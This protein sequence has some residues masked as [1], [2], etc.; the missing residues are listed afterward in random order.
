MTTMS[1]ESTDLWQNHSLKYLE[2]AFRSDRC[3]ILA[4]PDGYGKKIRSCGD[5]IEIFIK[6]RGDILNTVSY[7]TNGC[8][9]TIAC[10]NTVVFLI[11]GKSVN[12]AW[13]I[14]PQSI[15][16][17]L[18]TLPEHDYHCAEMAVDALHLALLNLREL[19]RSP[20]KRAY[21]TRN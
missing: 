14:T 17:Y 18:E 16:D 21:L 6:T 5:S 2:M 7:Y 15:A 10:A 12:E 19:Q 1:D 9:N 20:W 11:E 8:M 4:N 13:E 3:E